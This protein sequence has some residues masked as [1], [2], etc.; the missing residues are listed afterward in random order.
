MRQ[1]IFNGKPESWDNWEFGFTARA[2]VYEYDE[3]LSGGVTSPTKSIYKALNTATTDVDEK[4]L[5]ANYESNSLA[6]S[7]LVSSMDMKGDGCSVAIA[8]LKSCRTTDL[9]S[10]DAYMAMKALRDYYNS[11]PVATVQISDDTVLFAGGFK[12]KCN[13]CGKYGHKL[14]ACRLKQNN[15][16]GGGSNN[17][18]TTNNKGNSNQSTSSVSTMTKTTTGVCNYCKKTGHWKNECPVLKAK[19]ARGTGGNNN[20]SRTGSTQP[21]ERAE[22][23]LIMIEKYTALQMCNCDRCG[24]LG[25]LNKKCQTCFV[26]TYVTAVLQPHLMGQCTGCKHLGPIGQACEC[27]P[28]ALAMYEELDLDLILLD[29]MESPG[30]QKVYRL[31]VET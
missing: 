18:N 7:H 12:G 10:G 27:N 4:K 9:P 24:E 16:G 1:V 2:A 26:G 21:S 29:E 8:I 31:A 30:Q 20:N 6:Y 19:Q 3:L 14:A 13:H 28:D 17:N 23:A 5:I 15:G 11:K 22:V 25:Y